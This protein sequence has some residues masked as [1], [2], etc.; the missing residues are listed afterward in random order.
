[1][2]NT[3]KIC[4]YESPFAYLMSGYSASITVNSFRIEFLNGTETDNDFNRK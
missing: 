2:T 1:M 4:V 3:F